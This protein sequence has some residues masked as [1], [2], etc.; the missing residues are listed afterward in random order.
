MKRTMIQISGVFQRLMLICLLLTFGLHVGIAQ[1]SAATL[2]LEDVEEARRLILSNQVDFKARV[3]LAT[4]LSILFEQIGRPETARKLTL[5]FISSANSQLQSAAATTPAT[6]NWAAIAET[7]HAGKYLTAAKALQDELNKNP[8]APVNPAA[9]IIALKSDDMLTAY[10]LFYAELSTGVRSAYADYLLSILAAREK[11]VTEA[12]QMMKQAE[13]RLSPDRLNHWVAMDRAK[14]ATVMNEFDEAERL[15]NALIQKA[16]NDPH[17]LYLFLLLD[18]A[19]GQKD[20]AGRRLAQLVPKLQPDP[21]LLAQ[22]ATLAVRLNE[23]DAAARMLETHEAKVE[24]NR[25][26]YEAFALVKKAQGKTSESDVYFAKANQLK[27]TR[28]AVE[29]RGEQE[30]LLSQAL[31]SARQSS[32]PSSAEMDGVTPVSKAYLY[33]LE[34]N[35]GAAVAALQKRIETQKAEP[36]EY[37]ILQTLQRRTEK[38]SEAKTT[39]ARLKKAYPEFQPYY[40]LAHLADYAARTNDAKNAKAYYQ[41]L[42][43][44]FPKSN[45]AIA[46]VD[47]LKNNQLNA[48]ATIPI[49]VSPLLTRYH[50]YGAAFVLSEIINYWDETTTFAKVSSAIGVSAQR[51]I[52]F[53]EL[54]P[55]ILNGANFEINPVAPTFDAISAIITN[56]VPVVLCY[57]EMFGEQTLESLFLLVGA[58]PVRRVV[59]AEGVRGD[60]PHVLTEPELL[61]GIALALHPGTVNMPEDETTKNALTLGADQVRLNLDAIML[62]RK[63]IESSEAFTQRMASSASQTGGEFIPM[64]MAYARWMARRG[65]KDETKKYLEDIRKNCNS[66]GEYHFLNAQYNFSQKDYALALNDIQTARGLQPQ[67]PRWT[68]ALA[69]IL[70]TQDKVKEAIQTCEEICIQHPENLTTAAYLLSLYKRTGNTEKLQQ[71][72]Q[73]LKDALNVE[74]LPID[75]TPIE[76]KN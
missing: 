75:E 59:Y 5:E 22:A 17:T 11:R 37:I 51:G 3:D 55:V 47:W 24:A 43:K 41:E 10:Q 69:R 16:P 64:Q 7:V 68:L 8:S 27:E 18:F 65:Q 9:M 76:Q 28:V 36:T 50:Q 12:S 2:S 48:N 30:R 40:V 25:D 33:L 35:P 6:G 71:E 21:Y 15:L 1:E 52:Q 31:A 39:L 19:R 20:Q 73:R 72:T 29:T 57:G 44:A 38:L 67:H 49:K 42:I 58:D 23:T 34:N 62:A 61:S 53:H 60:D 63:E 54:I 46:A 74:T 4:R 32:G 70:Y 26:F 45:Q 56:R 13:G 66:I 14:L